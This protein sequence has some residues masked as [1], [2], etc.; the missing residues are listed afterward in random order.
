MQKD[1][2]DIIKQAAKNNNIKVTFYRYKKNECSCCFWP[3]KYD[4]LINTNTPNNRFDDYF[5]INY[6]YQKVWYLNFKRFIEEIKQKIN[7]NLKNKY[8]ITYDLTLNNYWLYAP[9]IKTI[10]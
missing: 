5:K 10:L 2:K 6:N 4:V 9:R 1:L 3:S 8:S 7:K